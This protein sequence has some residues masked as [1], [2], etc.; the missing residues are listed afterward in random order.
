MLPPYGLR[1]DGGH[2]VVALSPA[3]ATA[4]SV[5]VPPPPAAG[6]AR[7][8]LGGGFGVGFGGLYVAKRVVVD[9]HPAAPTAARTFPALGDAPDAPSN[10]PLTLAIR[11][12][13]APRR[14]LAP[15][16]PRL[17]ATSS[18]QNVRQEREQ[19][20]YALLGGVDGWRRHNPKPCPLPTVERDSDGLL[21]TSPANG[22]ESAVA[23]GCRRT[24]RYP[25]VRAYVSLGSAGSSACR[26]SICSMR[27]SREATSD[28][29]SVTSSPLSVSDS[30][31]SNQ[32]ESRLSTSAISASLRY[33]TL[34]PCSQ[35]CAVRS[36]T[37]TA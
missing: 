11:A 21:D 24:S 26:A 5:A 23:V 18:R 16:C 2:R 9:L 17:T 28:S 35:C 30:P 14:S 27:S 7:H 37:P 29:F 22:L 36:V 34:S 6:I 10:A 15:L 3:V 31:C 1:D 4:P 33:G 32:P 8:P 12:G 19:E 13:D 25:C 20:R